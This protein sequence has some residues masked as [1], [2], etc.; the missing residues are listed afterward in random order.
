VKLPVLALTMGDPA[1][2]GPEITAKALGRDEIHTM[3]IPLVVGDMALMQAHERYM[4]GRRC[5]LVD[6]VEALDTLPADGVAVFQ[7]HGPLRGVVAGTL[8]AE[9]GRAA[10]AY[11]YGAIELAKRG[12]IQGIVTAPLNKE[13]LHMGGDTHPGHTELLAESFGVRN[14]A[15]VLAAEDRYVF[16]V[17]THQ[18][19]RSAIDSLTVDAVYQR[20]RLAHLLATALGTPQETVAVAGVN[21][22]A[23][24]GGMFGTEER[25][26]ITPAV[27]KAVA[28]GIPA[29]GPV[30]ADVLFPRMVRGQYR[31]AIAMYHDQGHAVFKSLYFDTGVNITIGLP[32]IRTSVDHGTAFDIAGKGI[33]SEESMIEAVRAAAR[34]GNSWAHISRSAM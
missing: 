30:P 34:L 12:D 23:G 2:I 6:G 33:A 22:H 5:I 28:E 15:M 26:I 7:P 11:V 27:Q 3:C 32:V 14:Y 9:A 29:E 17:T 24:E 10:A 8:S 1:G 19:L 25:D 4:N 21:P 31:F 20:I 16:H 13:A 18:S